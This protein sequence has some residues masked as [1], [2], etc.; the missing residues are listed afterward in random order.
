[1]MQNEPT[2]EKIE[3]YCNQ[4]N[5]EKRMVVWIVILSGLLIGAFYSIISI[6]S[7]IDDAL[8]VRTDIIKY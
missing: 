1:M 4:E 2:L 6:N 5:R 3:D 7:V 8:K